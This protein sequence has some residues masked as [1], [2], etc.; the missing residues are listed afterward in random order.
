MRRLLGAVFLSACLAGCGPTGGGLRYGLDPEINAAAVE[1]ASYNKMRL[2]NALAADANIMVTTPATWYQVTEAGFNYVDDQCRAYFDE[3]F[4]L[5]RNRGR[6]KSGLNAAGQTT[7]AILA[8]TGTTIPAMAIVAQAFGIGIAATDIIAGTYLYQLPPA[9]TQSFVN[10]LQFALR[11]QA[12]AQRGLINSPTT[13]YHLIQEYLSLC[14]PPT[15]EAK[16]VEHLG[17]ARATVVRRGSVLSAGVSSEMQTVVGRIVSDASSGRNIS[18]GS[19]D[20]PAAGG[21]ANGRP[22]PPHGPTATLDVEEPLPKPEKAKLSAEGLT[23]EERKLPPAKKKDIQAALCVRPTGEFG[24]L[25]SET[26]KAI[27]NYLTGRGTTPLDRLTRG[28][29]PFLIEAYQEG[30]GQCKGQGPEHARA[31]G[32]FVKKKMEE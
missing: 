14:L 28:N 20:Q 1:Q 12:A 30:L 29:S 26:R 10:E 32:E 6:I 3:L 27:E 5:D 2:L 4:F 17:A 23:D 21:G 31:V 13:S 19:S 9:T 22:R 24:P 11:Q 25:G 16:I 18:G 15:I 8:I 7:N